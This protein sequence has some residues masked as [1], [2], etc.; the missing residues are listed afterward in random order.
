MEFRCRLGTPDGDV[1]ESVYVSDSE[2]H[3]RHELE[4]KGMCILSLRPRRGIGSL[5]LQM[6]RRRRIP[7]REFL[8]FNQELAT[9]L[10][11]GLPL[12][13]SVDI[14]RK[15]VPNPTFRAALDDIYE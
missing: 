4:H 10:K 12:V 1:I 9:L 15:R 2:T 14:L 11:A 13:Q 8:V 6:P 3:L 7:A 5:A